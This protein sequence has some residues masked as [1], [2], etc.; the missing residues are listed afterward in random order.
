MFNIASDHQCDEILIAE[1]TVGVTDAVL[2]EQVNLRLVSFTTV[3]KQ[4]S[5]WFIGS[6]MVESI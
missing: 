3:L 6:P 5:A 2:H 4:T 1:E